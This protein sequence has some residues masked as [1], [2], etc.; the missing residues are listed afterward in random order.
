[1]NSSLV[2]SFFGQPAVTNR[3]PPSLYFWVGGTTVVR[4]GWAIETNHQTNNEKPR[5]ITITFC[6][7]C[8][9][10]KTAELS[11]AE[12]C[13]NTISPLLSRHF[14]FILKCAFSFSTFFALVSACHSLIL[15]S[16]SHC[17]HCNVQPC[18]NTISHLLLGLL[19]WL[20]HNL[21]FL[22]LSCWIICGLGFVCHRVWFQRIWFG[23]N[24]DANV[25][26]ICFLCILDFVSK[27]HKVTFAPWVD[28]LVIKTETD[29]FLVSVVQ[30]CHFE[31][32]F[33]YEP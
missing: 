31:Q 23:N 2:H 25:S 26:D 14:L 28:Q 32:H 17:S 16:F 12:S 7:I 13:A 22:L 21:L 8:V 20:M 29:T 3:P 11:Q 4:W 9:A 24:W 19:L 27:P 33:C 6:N 1:M 5:K 30:M 10:K 18:A 15:I